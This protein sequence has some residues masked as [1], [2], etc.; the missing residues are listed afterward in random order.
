MV[1]CQEVE[2][3]KLHK[4]TEAEDEAGGNV[5][6]QGCNIGDTWEILLGI[7]TQCSHGEYRGDSCESIGVE[8]GLA[9]DPY[10]TLLK[11]SL[12]KQLCAQVGAHTKLPKEV[13]A[14]VESFLIQ[15]EIQEMIMVIEEDT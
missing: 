10:I 2:H 6:I 7:G 5:E 4:S 1:V 3:S 13:L 9:T 14:G 12:R 15:K 8:V 11:G